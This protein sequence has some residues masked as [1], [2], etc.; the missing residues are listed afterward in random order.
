MIKFEVMDGSG[1]GENRMPMGG[2]KEVNTLGF[3]NESEGWPVSRKTPFSGSLKWVPSLR[4][5][6]TKGE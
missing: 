6:G 4:C 2:T 3:D 5:D 1:E